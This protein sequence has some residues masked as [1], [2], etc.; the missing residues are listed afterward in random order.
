M[1]ALSRLQTW[2]A[3][4]C[5]GNWEHQE[6][7][8]IETLDNPGWRVT[9]NLTGTAL[10]GRPFTEV[11]VGVGADAHPASPRWMH[12]WSEDGLWQAATDERQLA[13]VLELF[14]DW[15]GVSAA[16]GAILSGG[17]EGS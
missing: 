17:A 4:Q 11:A 2:Y 5:D 15:A 12:C 16:T 13:H 1:D 10:E 9:I 14:L 8:R 3:A 6:G 7:I